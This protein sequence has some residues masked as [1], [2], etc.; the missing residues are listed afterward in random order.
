MKNSNGFTLV[1]L[2][3][4][5]AI[6]AI[7]AAILFPVFAQAKDAAKKVVALSNERQLGLAWMM[8]ADD[9]DGMVPWLTAGPNGESRYWWGMVIG[10]TVD[11]TQGPLYPYTKGKGIQADPSFPNELRSKVGITGYGYNYVF[12]GGGGVSY[13]SIP[14]PATKVGF[15][16]SAR[17]NSFQYVKPTLEANPLLDP[18]SNNYPGFQGRH[19]GLGTVLW[20]DGH[21]TVAHPA[22]RSGTF[23]YG[24]SA[25]LY[26]RNCLGDLTP[27][28]DTTSNALFDLN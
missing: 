11:E 15:A 1:E 12:L 26:R 27:N 7:L 28:G 22:Y 9:C 14:T 5:I 21:A 8:Y 18:P 4:V 3:V 23:G 10:N 17:I 24:F 25:D 6:I 19:A 16:S 13:A 2:L 20:T